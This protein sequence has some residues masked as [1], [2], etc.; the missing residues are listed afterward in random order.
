M[1][2][3]RLFRLIPYLKV[4]K[5]TVFFLFDANGALYISLSALSM[6]VQGAPQHR[7][8]GGKFPSA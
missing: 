1:I 5:S 2:R 8:R 3:R 6:F 4:R 7:G